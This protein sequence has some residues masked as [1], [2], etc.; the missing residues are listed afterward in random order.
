LV[1][2][3][4]SGEDALRVCGEYVLGV[5]RGRV[6]RSSN[7]ASNNFSEFPSAIINWWNI[8]NHLGLA[9]HNGS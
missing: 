1:P 7:A 4:D 3:S 2:T 9:D 5:E 8:A 6:S